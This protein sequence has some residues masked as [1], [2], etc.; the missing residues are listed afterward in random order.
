MK[1][2]IFV[3]MESHGHESISIRNG[4]ILNVGNCGSGVP[5]KIISQLS[6][7]IRRS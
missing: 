7:Q 6:I 5:V 4:I 3:Y 1:L 2:V